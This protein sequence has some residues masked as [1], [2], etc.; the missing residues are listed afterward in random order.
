VKKVLIL[1]NGIS[2]L[3]YDG[4]IRSWDG[5]V[6]GSNWIFTEYGEILTRLNGHI[7]PM[8]AAAEA[9]KK[10][11][12]S[13]QIW[14][15]HLGKLS[16][17]DKDFTCPHE[18][19]KDSGTT[20]VAQ[21]LHEGFEKIVCCGFDLGGPDVLSPDMAMQDKRSWVRRWRAI[22]NKWGLERIEFIGFDHKPYILSD[23]PDYEYQ[24]RYKRNRPHIPDADYYQ[25]FEK[26]TGEKAVRVIGDGDMVKVKYLRGTKVGFETEYNEG[27]ASILA[28]RGEVKILKKEKGGDDDK[29]SKK[30]LYEKLKE[31]EV[32]LKHINNY[33]M[34]ELEALAKDA[35]V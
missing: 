32:E 24:N 26:H 15:G 12:H 7:E 28:E 11:G 9:R 16:V 10:D 30:E 13:Y 33:N 25:A 21:A 34:D 3:S 35:G 5:E 18:Y 1:G 31:A 8:K 19:R 17:V 2:R 22:A 4:F 6:W 29:P 23:R 20:H 27:I 14:G